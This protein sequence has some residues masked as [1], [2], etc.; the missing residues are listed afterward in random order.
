MQLKS[1][2][3]SLELSVLKKLLLISIAIQIWEDTKLF[4]DHGLLLLL[5]AISQ[6]LSSLKASRI[7]S[8]CQ[9]VSSPTTTNN[10]EVL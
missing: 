6:R 5:P 1:T 2:E 4:K 7:S 3:R 10:E 9:A 8:W